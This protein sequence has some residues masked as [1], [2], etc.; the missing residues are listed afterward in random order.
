[1]VNKPAAQPAQ[2]QAD[3][4]QH[5]PWVQEAIDAGDAARAVNR[6]AMTSMAATGE[7]DRILAMV[8]GPIEIRLLLKIFDALVAEFPNAVLKHH[9]TFFVVY[10]EPQYSLDVNYGCTSC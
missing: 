4:P 10:E 7:F 1:M 5:P 8:R 2:E 6:D 9:G 3:D